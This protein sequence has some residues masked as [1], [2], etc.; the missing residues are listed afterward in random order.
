[1]GEFM[2]SKYVKVLTKD[3]KLINMDSIHIKHFKTWTNMLENIG[4]E[5]KEDEQFDLPVVNAATFIKLLEWAEHH[6]NDV[7]SATIETDP[8]STWDKNH[9]SFI[10]QI[11]MLELLEAINYLECDDIQRI[12]FKLLIGTCRHITPTEIR[13]IFRLQTPLNN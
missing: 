13:T 3:K 8:V 4:D 11:F 9:F 6:K 12:L 2:M 5:I 10:D 7:E 1:M